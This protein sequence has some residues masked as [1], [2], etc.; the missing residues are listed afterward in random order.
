LRHYKGK[1]FELETLEERILLSG[2]PLLDP[3][4][5][6]TSNSHPISLGLGAYASTAS[7][8]VQTF[9][10]AKHLKPSATLQ[11]QPG[12]VLGDIFAGINDDTDEEEL[13]EE[14]LR[15]EDVG[16]ILSQPELISTHE[17]ID[18]RRFERG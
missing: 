7:E 13:A 14:S 6:L 1:E 4:S 11:Y 9:D 18:N 8:S 2:D 10:N 3:L 16:Q 5:A 12:A 15:E 17:D